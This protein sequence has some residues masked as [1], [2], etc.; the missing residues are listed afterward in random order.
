MTTE[1][2]NP[3]G[4]P[5]PLIT[6]AWRK[7]PDLLNVRA[8][9]FTGA[10]RCSSVPANLSVGGWIQVFDEAD[11]TGSA[12]VDATGGMG[13]SAT[14]ESFS[15]TPVLRAPKPG[16]VYEYEFRVSF[17]ELSNPYVVDGVDNPPPQ[18]RVFGHT[19]DP[20]GT[21]PGNWQ[22]PEMDCLFAQQIAVP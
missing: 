9:A 14:P 16:H 8:I 17:V 19:D 10:V 12:V 5:K 6:Q 15:I 1:S 13:P 18:C 7:R 2:L 11:P 20:S 22:Q 3:R 4:P 21:G